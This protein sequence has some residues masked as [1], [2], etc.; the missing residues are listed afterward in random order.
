M[1]QKKLNEANKILLLDTDRQIRLVF[2]NEKMPHAINTPFYIPVQDSHLERASTKDIDC[3]L[4]FKFSLLLKVFFLSS[5]RRGFSSYRRRRRH[6]FGMFCD[7][8]YEF[9]VAIPRL[10]TQ[11]C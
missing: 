2:R 1:L 3:L 5:S 6:T 11:I 10:H 4:I 7:I 9:H 8:A